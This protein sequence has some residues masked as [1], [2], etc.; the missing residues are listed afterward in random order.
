MLCETLPLFFELNCRFRF[1]SNHMDHQIIYEIHSPAINIAIN[2]LEACLRPQS[3][4][5]FIGLRDS[6]KR[7]KS[8]NSNKAELLNVWTNQH[9]TFAGS[10]LSVSMF[11][12][13]WRTAIYKGSTYVNVYQNSIERKLQVTDKVSDQYF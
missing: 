6:S 1:R 11:N 8:S 12:S 4:K 2:D 13:M 7:P 5:T 10:P 3:K 9:V